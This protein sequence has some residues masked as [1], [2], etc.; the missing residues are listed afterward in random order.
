MRDG[1]LAPL[2][3][4]RDPSALPQ[5]PADL[6]HLYGTISGRDIER[7]IEFG[8][9]QSTL[10]IA[11]AMH[12]RGRGHLWSLDADDKWL[13]HTRAMLPE[14]LKRFVTFVHSPVELTTDHGVGAWRYSVVPEGR[15]DF[16][17]IDG[18]EGTGREEGGSDMT[19]NLI[20]MADRMNPGATG[21]IDHRWQTAMLTREKAGR[22]LKL[23]F[24]PS[25][26]S[27][28]F[29]PRRPRQG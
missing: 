4:S 2:L 18:P 13:A 8:S 17:L 23:W 12:D 6:L 20:D 16:I 26:E 22:R 21:F 9:S 28:A 24:I 15:W 19:A 29:A 25:L 10:F 14:H 5:D 7:A 3:R 11:Q 27:F 1:P